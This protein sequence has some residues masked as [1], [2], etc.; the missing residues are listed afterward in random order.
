[1]FKLIMADI[2]VLEKKIWMIPLSI[3]LFFFLIISGYSL[4]THK[5]MMMIPFMII[6]LVTLLLGYEL[7]RS[8]DGRRLHV[9]EASLPIGKSQI[10]IQKYIMLIIFFGIGVLTEHLL[11]VVMSI[12]GAAKGYETLLDSI[13][14]SLLGVLRVAIFVLPLFFLLKSTRK[15]FILFLVW[16]F[17]MYIIHGNATLE[18]L[19]ARYD[20]Q[21]TGYIYGLLILLSFITVAIEKIRLKNKVRLH[22]LLVIPLAL[23]F[24]ISIALLWESVNDLIA[25]NIF[26]YALPGRWPESYVDR[27]SDVVPKFFL[28]HFLITMIFSALGYY[29]WKF[30]G[31]RKLIKSLS[32]IVLLPVLFYCMENC[33]RIFI[34][35][36]SVIMTNDFQDP[37]QLDIPL[38]S[39]SQYIIFIPMLFVSIHYSKKFLSEGGK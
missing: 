7:M 28:F 22:E 24:P 13:N 16:V 30:C 3:L 8:S 27:I 12:F 39:L 2:K 29:L 38:F 5:T 23:I 19:Y 37:I 25:K 1:M 21:K 31:M 32:L 20:S 36:T 34:W 26:V 33:L 35:L 11:S 15:A 18:L 17:G 9:Q 10:V 4:Y 6:P 14:V